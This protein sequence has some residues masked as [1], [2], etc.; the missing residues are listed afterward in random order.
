MRALTINKK[1]GDCTLIEARNINQVEIEN[2][3]FIWIDFENENKASQREL[4]STVFGIS[5]LAIDD[6]Q[7]D[8]HPPKY[9]KFSRYSFMLLKAFDANTEDIDFKIL[10]ISFFLGENFLITLHAGESP[11]INAIWEKIIV[12]NRIA[13]DSFLASYQIIKN[14]INRYTKVVLRLEDRL[15]EIE[16]E[17]LRNPTDKLLS[18]LV[19]YNSKIQYLTRIFTNQHRVITEVL[20]QESSLQSE[21]LRH[22]YQDIEEQM[23]RL[24]GLCGLLHSVIQ[25]LM[26]AYI[27]VS[28]HKLNKIMKILTIIAVIFLPL[29]FIAGIYGMNFQNMPELSYKYSY[30]IALAFMAILVSCLLILFKKIKWI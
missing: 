26:D 18:E 27:S 30:Y 23:E 25:N 9:E 14:I 13:P 20:S 16:D 24:A 7:K 2:D 21:E 4:L 10:H 19:R 3:S 6:A 1:S 29:S 12:N 11:S 15:E 22:Q 8:R 17:M 28:S 5:D